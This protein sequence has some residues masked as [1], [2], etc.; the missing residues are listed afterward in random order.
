M[1]QNE[2]EQR[3]IQTPIVWYFPPWPRA[4]SRPLSITT[5]GTQLSITS[6]RIAQ[7][8]RTQFHDN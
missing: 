2:T 5:A 7:Q 3:E 1:K 4:L 6:V 8:P